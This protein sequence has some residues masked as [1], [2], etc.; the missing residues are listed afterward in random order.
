MTLA[1]TTGTAPA[2]SAFVRGLRGCSHGGFD[3]GQHDPSA[4]QIPWSTLILT[5]VIAGVLS[6]LFAIG[7]AIVMVPLLV[8]RAGI[9]QRQAA[10]TSLVAIIPIAVVSSAAYLVHAD[11]DI[12][13]LATTH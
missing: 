5:G 1:P 13:Q 11:V 6:G 10:A 3:I 7:G 9:D 12:A 4:A 8:W 2:G